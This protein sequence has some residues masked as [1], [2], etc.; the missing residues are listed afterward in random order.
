M[1][2][3]SGDAL[4]PQ[5]PEKKR[6]HASFQEDRRYL[7]QMVALDQHARGERVDA[8]LE[9]KGSVD[10]SSARLQAQNA[11]LH[12]RAQE[13]ADQ[14]KRAYSEL[15]GQ[16][17]NPH[18]VARRAHV[19][20]AADKER[21]AIEQR[22]QSKQI[23]ILQHLEVEKVLQAR[24][25]R[26]EREKQAFEKKYQAEMGRSAV[27]ERTKSFLLSRTGKEQLD[28]TGKIVRVYPSQE[29]ALPDKSFGLGHNL[30]H[31][32]TQRQKIVDKVHAKRFHHDAVAN[33]VLLPRRSDS[34]AGGGASTNN[35]NSHPGSAGSRRSSNNSG[36]RDVTSPSSSTMAGPGALLSGPSLPIPGR[37][38]R[39]INHRLLSVSS[40]DILPPIQNQSQGHGHGSSDAAGPS[41]K[42]GF[43]KPK[44]SVL[45]Q[46]MLAKAREKQKSNLFQ[47]QVV[48][49]KEFTGD[50][51][52]S[53][54]PVLWFKDFD[55]GTP[56][57]LTFTLTNVSNTFN[58]F[59]LVE[60]ED[61]TL[62]ECFEIAFEKPGR[63]SAG[64][65]CAIRMSFTAIAA[66]DVDTFL[67]A[68]AQTGKFQIPIR[69]TCKKAVPV[70][71]QREIQFKDVVA[72]EKK[73]IAVTLENQGALPLRFSVQKVDKVSTSGGP[74]LNDLN[75]DVDVSG[76]S[77]E[78]QEALSASDEGERG[79]VATVEVAEFA[80]AGSRNPNDASETSEA[81]SEVEGSG[82]TLTIPECTEDQSS[83]VYPSFSTAEQSILEFAKS[84]TVYKPEGSETPLRHTK[85][86]VVAPYS[87]SV[88]SFTFTPATPMSISNQIFAIDLIQESS[89]SSKTT[90]LPSSSITVSA[91]SNQVPIFTAES[92]LHLGCCV[93]EKLYRHQLEVCNRGKVALK[94]Q[95]RVPKALDG[96][97]EFTPNMGYVQA[98]AT[99]GKSSTSNTAGKFV[100]QV[101]FRPQSGMWKRLE[102]KGFGSES[103]GF[104]A[105]PVQVI[106]PDQVVPMFFLLVARLTTSGLVFS[107][108]R[109]DF[110]ECPLGHSV[111]RKLTI[112]NSAR[113]PQHFGFLKLPQ[114][115]K[116]IGSGDGV[117]VTL[118]PFEKKALTLIYQP[119]T[120]VPLR[121]KLCVRTSLSKEYYL[122]CT[123]SCLASPLVLSHSF[124]QL[125]ATQLGQSQSFSVLCSNVSEKPQSFELLLPEGAHK[126]LRVT[127][128][129]SRV[130]SNAGVR[131][132]IVFAPT[133]EILAVAES[134]FACAESAESPT[135]PV[136]V[137][138]STEEDQEE[139]QAE[140]KL[141][142][143]LGPPRNEAPGVTANHSRTSPTP[144]LPTDLSLANSRSSATET[145]WEV[146]IPPEDRSVHHR[147]TVLCFR[148]SET[149]SGHHSSNSTN[150]A[151]GMLLSLQVETTTIDPQ[152]FATPAK[153]DYS[154]VAIGQS[155]VME[156]TLTNNSSKS[157]V[158]FSAKSLH[159]LG[160]FRM[161]NSLR[162]IKSGGGA[163]VV[164]MEFKPQSPIIYED[165]LELSSP[166]I[167]T[168]RIPLRGEGIN[169]SLSFTPADGWL[170]FKDLLARNK[171]AHEL[172]LANAS[173]F[174]LT[175]AIVLW[176]EGSKPVIT[177]NGLPVFT[178]TPSEALIPA[179]GS[180]VVKV[181]FNPVAQRSEH[182]KQTFRIKVPN[183]SERH[184]LTLSGRCWEDQLYLFAPAQLDLSPNA[185]A[186][187]DLLTA[188][189]PVAVPPPV[190]A[191]PFDLPPG[192][193]LSALS[194]S[195][196]AA[197]PLLLSAGL[198]K[199]QQTLTLTFSDGDEEDSS[200][201]D[202]RPLTQQL[203]IGST[204]A[205]SDDE[206]HVSS[207]Q[208]TTGKSGAPPPAGAAAGSFELVLVENTAH[209]EYAKLFS[210]E[211]MKG[212]LTVGQQ[213]QVRVTYTPPSQSATDAAGATDDAADT[214]LREKQR[215]LVVSQWIEV[216]AVCTL[217][218]GFL[219]RQL[220]PQAGGPGQ[221]AAAPKG[222]NGAI[223][224][225]VRTV[226]LTLRAKMKT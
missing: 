34:E 181:A 133:E 27:E 216:Q 180:L 207:G 100:V 45:E 205:P 40:A 193:N 159:V 155:L 17:K 70:L 179:Q 157:D 92:E 97:V 194:G 47:K 87:S 88:I 82:A 12:R 171:A 172:V 121:A 208:V 16:G 139:L 132:E 154:Q 21:R 55:V 224:S 184:V 137:S 226:Q 214:T 114:E 204:L 2:T 13:L 147:W 130:E 213:L 151:G 4:L 209:P 182:Y 167:G 145:P 103:L 189:A 118:L 211:P 90:R 53:D 99:S 104:M 178:F 66:A 183:E 56:L 102:R 138:S 29:T 60:I 31:D 135:P 190:I 48:W 123:G 223:D 84:F 15:L 141:G 221:P 5:P 186:I 126:F 49:G 62:R 23:D 174:P 81:S 168:I 187:R 7:A 146:A 188:T 124:V 195:G 35:N 65:S 202:G 20:R 153:L 1:D 156:L 75:E 63:M 109:V 148:R 220:P 33:P 50:A 164:K 6:L 78:N 160:G 218:G 165:E 152:V 74:E 191:D 170:D 185:P 51:F 71:V 136:P 77:E 80:N 39:E 69:C 196:A 200:S 42:K 169:P 125:G 128:S 217:R 24:R 72:G 106:V 198:R 108:D 95:V 127:P 149:S 111:S 131:I 28:P 176:P 73:T 59:K 113:L 58:Y 68:V 26:L 8:I 140:D 32:A 46:Q 54:P 94:I 197:N 120:A 163:H 101:K 110:G 162:L 37:D 25:E 222:G 64:M 93:F 173:S 215:E 119:S 36:E 91:E 96:V 57:T 206:S 142:L 79:S 199:T 201:S 19:T 225:D 89:K 9:L 210:L 41:L 44:R 116:I 76:A 30:V 122:Q 166:S 143:A 175:Y 105:V 144:A 11:A 85:S 22:I 115:V 86:G 134:S 219:W 52:L 161:I 112:E 203:L 212:A 117:G 177:S 98:A 38:L 61:E 83:D 14:E 129:V 67:R 150:S 10:A 43:G 158:L 192:V 107:V 18:E 3:G